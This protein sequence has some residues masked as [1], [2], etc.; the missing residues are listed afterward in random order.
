M[1][2]LD[3]AAVQH[4]LENFN[5][6]DRYLAIHLLRRL[7]YVSFTEFEEWIQNAVNSLIGE[8]D[9]RSRTNRVVPC[10]KTIGQMAA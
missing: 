6:A 10:S 1:D 4:W 7:R 9:K 2:L 5:I 3:N 8:I